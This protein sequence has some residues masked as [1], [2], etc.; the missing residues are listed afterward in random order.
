MHLCKGL[1]DAQ[2]TAGKVYEKDP[3]TLSKV[4]ILV[5]KLNT[6]QHITATLSSPMVNVMSNDDNCVVCRKEGHIGG[7][8]PRVQ[9][10]N[11]DD[12]VILHKICPKKIALSGNLIMT[13]GLAATYVASK[14]TGRGHTPSITYT[15]KGTIL[16]GQDHVIDHSVTEAP[17]TIRGTHSTP[18]LPMIAILITP[19]QTDTL[20]DIPAWI[21]QTDAGT[22][23]LVT[24]HARVS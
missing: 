18:Y 12:L 3:Q 23:H 16:I 21:P 14:S 9:C 6:A 17:V 2:N 20:E 22:T 7:H 15:A 13:T 11:C 24:H 10:Y 5:G 4:I 8:C 19:L 1:R